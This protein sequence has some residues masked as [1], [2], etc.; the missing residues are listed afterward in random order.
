MD[1]KYYISYGSNLS[2]KQM[3]E[4]CPHATV[5]GTG[6]LYGW[7]LMFRRSATIERNPIKYTPVLVW[8]ISEEDEEQLDKYEWF[9]YI[10]NKAHIRVTMDGDVPLRITAMTYIMNEERD[11]SMPSSFYYNDL[12]AQYCRLGFPVSILEEAIID[13]LGEE[14]GRK[15]LARTCR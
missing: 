10:Y 13:S 9:P 5:L 2:I 12:K 11:L 7:R 3:A 15:F 6:R 4:R 14:A 8:E 1:K